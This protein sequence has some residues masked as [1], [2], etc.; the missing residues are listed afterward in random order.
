MRGRA[1]SPFGKDH[2]PGSSGHAYTGGT[3]IDPAITG[4]L[5]EER[6]DLR[7]ALSRTERGRPV[8]AAVRVVAPQGAAREVVP[9]SVRVVLA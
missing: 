6:R 2:A 7:A 8:T 5:S 1:R 4:E 3:S 9:R